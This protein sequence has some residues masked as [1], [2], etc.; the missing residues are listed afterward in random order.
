MTSIGCLLI[1]MAVAYWRP[2]VLATCPAA[3]GAAIFGVMLYGITHTPQIAE[4]ILL[5]I[6]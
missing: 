5:L 2:R 1:L 4:R 3:A 6:R